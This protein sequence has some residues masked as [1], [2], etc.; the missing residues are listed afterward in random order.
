MKIRVNL[1]KGIIYNIYP[2]VTFYTSIPYSR[3]RKILLYE[4]GYNRW[5]I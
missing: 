5:T 2:K 3:L 1:K 4:L